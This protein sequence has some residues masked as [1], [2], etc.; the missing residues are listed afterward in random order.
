MARM[1]YF[2]LDFFP[3]FLFPSSPLSLFLSFSVSSF[4][5]VILY[6][7]DFFIYLK[8]KEEKNMKVGRLFKVKSWKTLKIKLG[9]FY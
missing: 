3:S 8:N 2:F 1:V 9:N 7:S 4:L 6:D 5:F